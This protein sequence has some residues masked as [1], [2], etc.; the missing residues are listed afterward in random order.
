MERYIKHLIISAE[1]RVDKFLESQ[2][3][4]PDS[5]LYGGIRSHIWEA[6]PTIYMMANAVA[7][8]L[9]KQSRYYQDQKLYD[10]MLLALQFIRNTQRDDGS[11]DY[12]SC[13]FK[14]AADTAFCFKRL[15]AAYQL[16]EKQEQSQ[17][18][19]ILQ[20]KYMVIMKDALKAICS[21][22]FH[23][24]NHRWGIAAALLQGANLF[25]KEPAFA[26][27]LKA[28]ADEY[29]AEGI[30]IDEDGEYAERSTGNYNAVVNNSMMTLYEE[31]GDRSDDYLQDH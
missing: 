1:Q 30:D 15:A 24:P 27:K 4:N 23:T 31:T 29:L 17:E 10:S 13:N 21:G 3:T 19:Y 6:K 20:M 16:M 25:E 11:F 18:L 28:R 12:P 26:R 14:S 5:Y 22:G 8:Y 9:N 7:L 2:I